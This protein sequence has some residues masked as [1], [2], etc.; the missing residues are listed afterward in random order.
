MTE[1]QLHRSVAQYLALV[2]KPPTLWNTFPAGGGGKA[3]G[4]RLKAMGLKPGWPDLIVL[5]PKG[6][7]TMV[8]GLE[9]K[10]GRNRQSAE[11]KAVAEQFAGLPLAHLAVCR[12]IDDV[13]S[14]LK[15]WEIIR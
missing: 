1:D 5:H 9:L 4:Q 11:Q 15:A 13:A 14:E 7:L 3:R 2:L 12:S 8:L 6:R 10:C